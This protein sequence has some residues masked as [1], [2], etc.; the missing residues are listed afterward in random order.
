MNYIHIRLLA[1]TPSHTTKPIF[2]IQEYLRA[3]IY[4]YFRGAIRDD[5]IAGAKLCFPAEPNY[6]GIETPNRRDERSERAR[7]N[8]KSKLGRGFDFYEGEITVSGVEHRI[9][10]EFDIKGAKH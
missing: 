1:H 6:P 7:L 8:F 3:Q 10:R 5:G 9:P 4:G 2:N